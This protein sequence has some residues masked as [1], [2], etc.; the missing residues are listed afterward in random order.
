MPLQIQKCIILI[1]ALFTADICGADTYYV[2]TAST[3]SGDGTTPETSGPH[4]AWKNISEITGL[5]AG[6]S[7]LF[8]RGDTWTEPLVISESGQVNNVITFDAYGLGDKPL[9]DLS[10][11]FSHPGFPQ[12][13]CISVTNQNYVAIKNFRLKG[14]GYGAAFKAYGA[15]GAEGDG[16]TIKVHDV[17]VLSS[18]NSNDGLIA[19]DGFDLTNSA[20]VEFYNIT[21]TKCRRDPV[22]SNPESNQCLTLHSFSKAKVHTANFSD[23]C[24]LIT[25]VASA[26]C[27]VY[28]L[29][30]TTGHKGSII[31]LGTTSD[32]ELVIDGGTIT[33][34]TSGGVV[35]ADGGKVTLKNCTI[36]YTY[37]GGNA[38]FSRCFGGTLEFKNNEIQISGSAFRPLIYGGTCI[39]NGNRINISDTSQ[40]GGE[41][42]GGVFEVENNIFNITKSG[43]EGNLFYFNSSDSG[44]YIR[45]NVFNGV[46]GWRWLIRVVSGKQPPELV[47]NTFYHP[48]QT[49]TSFALLYG[50]N[51]GTWNIYN[52]IFYNIDDIADSIGASDAHHN[53]YYA[54]EALEGIGS[55]TADPLF[56]NS[57][58]ED[59]H[60]KSEGWRWDLQRKVWTWDDATSRCID[61]GNTGSPL[62]NEPLA[63]PDDPNN[64]WGENLRINMGAYGGTAEASIAPHGWAILA[65][66]TNDGTV[67]LEDIA[68]HGKNWL[69]N[70]T[71]QP[72]DLNRD[73][74]VDITDFELLAKDWLKQ[75]IW[76]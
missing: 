1:F 71:E 19:D 22:D 63:V 26:Y 65:D 43:T 14:S 38:R 36:N 47:N 62:A 32:F 30:G 13:C 8:H 34:S 23:S 68:V 48:S 45:F 16:Y 74:T 24:N 76:F 3:G 4:A 20:E 72:A 64:E 11:L 39:L 28:D 21:A 18:F 5:F 31:G 60:L 58:N 61:A 46:L 69:R 37:S 67:N 29:T 2:D 41:I 35:S 33:H 51:A 70:E 17:D 6:D 25:N 57:E 66:S 15:A 54:S 44:S 56:V 42:S 9:I 10:G 55:I 53:C 12:A 59:F 75:T 49:P 7:V 52:N 73:G 27:E 40:N 50:S